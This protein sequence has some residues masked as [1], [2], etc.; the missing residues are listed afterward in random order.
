ML[1][2]VGADSTLSAG[3]GVLAPG[4]RLVMVGGG[5]GSMT[6]AKGRDLPLGWHV[7]APFWGPRQDLEAVVD[8][9]RRGLIE[10]DVEIVRFSETL[11]AYRRLRDGDVRGR[12]VVVPDQAAVQPPSA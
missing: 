1:D 7:N 8:L 5:G 3:A 2:F 10:A 4:G 9:A 6:V 12:I 11:D